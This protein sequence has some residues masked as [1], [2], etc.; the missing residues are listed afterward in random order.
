MCVCVCVCVCAC[1]CACVCVNK[2]FLHV[3]M[4]VSVDI[5]CT[6]YVCTCPS[7][8]VVAPTYNVDHLLHVTIV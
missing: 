5:L 1:V 7:V 2:V 6:K 3:L 8:V 4:S